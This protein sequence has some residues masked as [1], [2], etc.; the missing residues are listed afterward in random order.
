M[1]LVVSNAAH[2]L[3]QSYA[4][5]PRRCGVTWEVDSLKNS[6]LWLS[7]AQLDYKTFWMEPKHMVFVQDLTQ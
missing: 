6:P 5:S 4:A 1:R 2:V 7:F 3:T